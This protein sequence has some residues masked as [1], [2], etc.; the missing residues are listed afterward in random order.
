MYHPL[1]NGRSVES[2]ANFSISFDLGLR[3]DS[4]QSSQEDREY[5]LLLRKR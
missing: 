4:L 3:E 2:G 1:T 5:E